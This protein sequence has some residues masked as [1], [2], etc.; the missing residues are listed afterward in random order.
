MVPSFLK[1][2]QYS[3]NT[4]HLKVLFQNAKVNMLT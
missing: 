3:N 4:H 2:V 1:T